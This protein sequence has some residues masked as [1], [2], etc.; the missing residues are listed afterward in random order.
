MVLPALGGT[1]PG[2]TPPMNCARNADLV[3]GAGGVRGAACADRP[4]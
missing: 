1:S 4:Y 2:G 3:G